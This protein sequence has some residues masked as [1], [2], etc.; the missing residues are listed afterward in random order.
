MKWFKK[1]RTFNSRTYDVELVKDK[2]EFEFL[3][4][5]IGSLAQVIDIKEFATVRS[6]NKI[7]IHIETSDKTLIKYLLKFGFEEA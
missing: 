4:N 7:N 6:I 5:T 2:D 3:M 1:V